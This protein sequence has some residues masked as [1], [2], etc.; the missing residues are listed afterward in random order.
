MVP[1][2]ENKKS[3]AGCI[4]LEPRRKL[5]VLPTRRNSNI[6][7]KIRRIFFQR[8]LF[9]R[10]CSVV[11]LVRVENKP[12]QINGIFYLGSCR[13]MCLAGICRVKYLQVGTYL[14]FTWQGQQVQQALSGARSF[15]GL[16]YILSIGTHLRKVR[17]QVGTRSQF[18]S[19][20][21]S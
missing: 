19:R 16:L 20:S 13:L 21:L 10:V 1:T 12:L 8:K 6:S 18:R 5:S 2:Q 14:A 15:R 7:L 3:G 17:R 9:E 4:V 11:L